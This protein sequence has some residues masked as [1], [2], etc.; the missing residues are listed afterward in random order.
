MLGAHL[1]NSTS[2]PRLFDLLANLTHGQPREVL[3]IADQILGRQL[4]GTYAIGITEMPIAVNCVD[5]AFPPDP[6]AALTDLRHTAGPT[7]P[8]RLALLTDTYVTC[9][10]WPVPV[11]ATLSVDTTGL[12]TLLVVSTTGDNMTPYANGVAL[13]DNL[14]AHLLTYQGYRHTAYL[15]DNDCVNNTVNDYLISPR[16]TPENTHC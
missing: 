8:W 13:V 16:T 9:P 10:Q 12:P 6:V 2:W 4:N 3:N 14:N 1:Y 5:A 11:T 7:E 15:G